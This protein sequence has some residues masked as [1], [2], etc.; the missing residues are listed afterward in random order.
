VLCK[1]AFSYVI[2]DRK[3]CLPDIAKWYSDTEFKSVKLMSKS[4]LLIDD[5]ILTFELSF[6]NFQRQIF[7]F[8]T[9]GI[10]TGTAVD[11]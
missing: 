1:L 10:T 4:I 7:I 3:T 8:L 11:F 9:D 5:E 6:S 2:I